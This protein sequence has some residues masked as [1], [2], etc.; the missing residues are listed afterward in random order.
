[1]LL[2]RGQEIAQRIVLLQ[3]DFHHSKAEVAAVSRVHPGDN[4]V[5][6]LFA[7]FCDGRETGPLCGI[8][9]LDHDEPPMP[10][11]GLI[12]LENGVRGGA[13]SGKKVENDR[14]RAG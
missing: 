14:V 4:A 9:L 8:R 2:L 7:D 1:V 3:G 6:P 11:I 10:P 12:E 13:S 5:H